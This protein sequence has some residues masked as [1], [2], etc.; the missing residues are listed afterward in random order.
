MQMI[1][2]LLQKKTRRMTLTICGMSLALG[3][4]FYLAAPPVLAGNGGSDC[5]EN[6]CETGGQCYDPTDCVGGSVCGFTGYWEPYH[7]PYGNCGIPQ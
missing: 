3:T 4:A 2:T 5:E 6:Q 7:G 1:S